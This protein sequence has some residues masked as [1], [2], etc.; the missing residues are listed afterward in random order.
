M[1]IKEKAKEIKE[2]Y[3]RKIAIK[4]DI[5]ISDISEEDIKDVQILTENNNG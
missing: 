3:K 2:W 1:D 5:N 4:E